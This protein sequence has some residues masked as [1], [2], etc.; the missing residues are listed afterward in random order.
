MTTLVWHDGHIVEP[1]T[2]IVDA[3]DHGLLMGDGVFETLAVHRGRPR[4]LERH[5]RRLRTGLERIDLD[6]PST[7]EVVR[8]AIDELMAASGLAEARVRVTVTAGPGS[9]PR[10]RGDTPTVFVTIAPLGPV[11]SSVSLHLVAWARNERSALAGIKSTNW[12]ENAHA[13]RAAATAGFDNALFCD[14]QGRLS[15]CAT[16]NVFLVIDDAILTPST[17]AGCLPGTVRESLLDA[18]VA[19]EADLRPVD[20][21]RADGVFVTT[22]TTGVVPVHAIDDRSFPV[23]LPAFA[24]AREAL[25]ADD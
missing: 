4:S 25:D 14:T 22:A 21:E 20:L 5:L 7:D 9:S 13:L 1:S 8:D 2:P 12:A 6:H 11:P 17:S 19:T 3:T 24:R 18:A 10:E 23:D 15:E 16:A